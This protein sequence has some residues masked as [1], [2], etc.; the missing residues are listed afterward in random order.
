MAIKINGSTIIDDSRKGINFDS[1]SIGTTNATANLDVDGTLN[2]SGVSTFQNNVHLLDDDKL[3]F[4]G[5]AGD[6]GDLQIYHNGSN[7][8]I[9]N[10]TGELFIRDNG[11]G[12]IY[13]QPT[14]GENSVKANSNGSVE[15][16]YDNSKKFETTGYGVTITGG[17]NVSGVST[18]HRI[19]GQATLEFNSTLET[20]DPAGGTG[21]DTANDAAIALPSGQKI[22]GY[23]DGYIRNLLSWTNSSDI[24]IGQQNTSKIRG[25]QL[26]PGNNAGV[27]IHYG[28]SSDNIK[29]ETTNYGATITGG[30]EVSGIVTASSYRGD[31]SQLTGVEAASF[32]F[33]TGVSNSVNQ[34]ATGIG[35]TAV[36]LPSTSGKKYIVHSILATNVASGNTDEVNFIG[37]FEF[38]GGE[39]SYFGYQIPV[40]TGMAVEMLKQPQVLNPS[41]KIIIRSTDID[42]NGADDIIDVYISYE[43]KTSTDLVGVGLGAV[44]LAGTSATTV[45]TSTS[46]PSVVQ[47]I[48]LANRTDTGAK[49]VSVLVGSRYLVDNLIVPKY[50]SIEILDQ[51]KRIETNDTIKVQLDEGGSKMIRLDVQ[52]SAKKIS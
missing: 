42:R 23:D 50:A 43:E 3:H 13:L 14:P 28:G 6:D 46:N 16:Y 17:L 18:F 33:N 21:T 1:V 37:A 8:F 4:G 52:V 19:D 11:F 26:K 34:V 22:V 24:E 40:Q 5:A 31:G 49:S 27:K 15:L 29:F 2:V 32:L 9:D 36:T 51:L 12:A 48:R 20:Y 39:T 25:I 35:T 7:S 45:Y 41:D 47:S 44:G 30:L 10:T 38:N